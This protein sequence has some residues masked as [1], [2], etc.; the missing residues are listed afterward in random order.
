MKYL[1]LNRIVEVHHQ[2]EADQRPNRPANWADV[3][4]LVVPLEVEVL[5][6]RLKYANIQLN[7]FEKQ[8]YS[9]KIHQRRSR[10]VGAA[11]Y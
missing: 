9:F 3:V 5:Q 11:D 2:K 7:L 8:N 6:R 4:S 10:V 1:H